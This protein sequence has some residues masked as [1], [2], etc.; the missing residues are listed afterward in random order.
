MEVLLDILKLQWNEDMLKLFGALHSLY[1]DN[2]NYLEKVTSFN[3]ILLDIC[4]DLYESYDIYRFP[5]K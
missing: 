4:M 3:L 1:N 2:T 5:W